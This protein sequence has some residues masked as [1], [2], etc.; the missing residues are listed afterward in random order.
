ML[1]E[2][3]MENIKVAYVDS[4]DLFNSGNGQDIR[5]YLLRKAVKDTDHYAT[6][7]LIF[8]EH[9]PKDMYKGEASEV[10]IYIERTGISWQYDTGHE[11]GGRP[12][13]YRSAMK[14]KLVDGKMELHEKGGNV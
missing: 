2:S 14:L 13:Q 4:I 1:D 12:K 11:V 6:D 10:D 8:L 9:A 5:E 3:N 7:I